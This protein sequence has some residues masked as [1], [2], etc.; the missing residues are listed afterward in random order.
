M[1]L[2]WSAYC[3]EIRFFTIS[4]SRGIK[5]PCDVLRCEIPLTVNSA[6]KT[7]SSDTAVNLL[8]SSSQ[9]GMK[10]GP[11]GTPATM[12]LFYQPRMVI[13]DECG[14][15]G[16]MRNGRL[17]RNTRRNPAPVPLPPQHISH[18]LTRE[19]HPGRLGGKPATNCVIY[20]TA[21]ILIL[22]LPWRQRYNLSHKLLK[23]DE[24]KTY[25]G[26]GV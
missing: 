22:Y 1:E 19:R 3:W 17:D 26:T 4:S 12:G 5:N 14:A 23:H 11:L 25:G 2:Y 15:Y 20:V 6:N 7:F 13:M 16:I 10:L 18:D 9:S 21:Y 8:F 24:K